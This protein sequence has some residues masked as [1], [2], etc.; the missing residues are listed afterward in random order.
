MTVHSVGSVG[1]ARQ[2]NLS[3]T[4]LFAV[5]CEVRIE[6]IDDDHAIDA[7]R[8]A[9][10]NNGMEFKWNSAHIVPKGLVV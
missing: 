7:V 9:I 3:D 4:N 5:T 2:D 10:L 6:A 1:L 8:T